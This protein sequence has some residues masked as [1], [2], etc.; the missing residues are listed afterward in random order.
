ME[1]QQRGSLHVILT[2]DHETALVLS[3]SAQQRLPQ[4]T[5]V[6]APQ[7]QVQDLVEEVNAGAG[8]RRA[9][10]AAVIAQVSSMDISLAHSGG[11]VI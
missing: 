2:E 3:P 4:A 8:N 9:V 6:I 11:T 10:T 5:A 7:P 1:S